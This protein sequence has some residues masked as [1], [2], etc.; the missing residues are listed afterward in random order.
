MSIDSTRKQT[1]GWEINSSGKMVNLAADDGIVIDEAAPIAESAAMPITDSAFVRT[2]PPPVPND[3]GR[4]RRSTL[5][6]FN[7]EMAVLESSA[8]G[9]GRRRRGAAAVALASSR[10]LRGR[11]RGVG[12]G[13]RRGAVAPT[14]RRRVARPGVATG[15]IAWRGRALCY[16]RD[17]DNRGARGRGS[18][19]RHRR[20][21]RFCDGRRRCRGG[22]VARGLGQG[23]GEVRAQ[24]AFAVDEQQELAPPLDQALRVVEALQ[25]ATSLIRT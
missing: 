16:R 6:S 19:S 4:G 24:Q 13:R 1:K 20:E 21:R 9:R 3:P 23:Q 14:R 5:D 10:H 7:E 11:R 17:G 18:R 15:D 8:R 22:S 12:C 25:L 2:E